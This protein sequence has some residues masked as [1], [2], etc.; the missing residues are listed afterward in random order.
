MAVLSQ[1]PT[2]PSQPHFLLLK[3]LCPP[4]PEEG[5]S[6]TWTYVGCWG[7]LSELATG[8]TTS[9]P[10]K[11]CAKSGHRSDLQCSA[12]RR[13]TTPG[14]GSAVVLAHPS[15][16][17]TSLL[18]PA[19]EQ[20]GYENLPCREGGG[21]CGL[22]HLAG[23]RTTAFHHVAP[24]AVACFVYWP[25]AN[26]QPR[27]LRGG[28]QLPHQKDTADID[29]YITVP[30]EKRGILSVT[31]T[32]HKGMS[33]EDLQCQVRVVQPSVG[34]RQDLPHIETRIASHAGWR[35]AFPGSSSAMPSSAGSRDPGLAPTQ[36]LQ[37]TFT[38]GK[39]ECPGNCRPDSLTSIPGKVVHKILLES[40]SKHMRDKKETGGAVTG[41]VDEGRAVGVDYL[42]FSK[43]FNTISHNIIIDKLTTYGLDK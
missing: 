33:K 42:G 6:P 4:S 17:H 24:A 31:G 14:L 20:H 39:K 43:A 18:L 40:I 16:E 25:V 27:A 22:S 11:P 5:G 19:T 1:G 7:E 10:G 36:R 2:D 32:W 21:V 23:G 30:S 13:T 28:P 12:G 15:Q 3:S 38:K 9:T 41:L 29:L 35:D 34:Q 8:S 26:Q 37:I